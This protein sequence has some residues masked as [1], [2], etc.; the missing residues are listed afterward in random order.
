MTEPGVWTKETSIWEPIS[1]GHLF[2][3]ENFKRD[4]HLQPYHTTVFRTDFTIM[5]LN[6]YRKKATSLFLNEK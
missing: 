6:C 4:L 5:F 3:N 1:M 2:A